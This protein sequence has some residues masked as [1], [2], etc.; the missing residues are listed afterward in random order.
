MIRL[1]SAKPLVLGRDGDNWENSVTF[2]GVRA[3]AISTHRHTSREPAFDVTTGHQP[4]R[5]QHKYEET[6]ISLTRYTL[7]VTYGFKST[8]HVCHIPTPAKFPNARPLL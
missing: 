8:P 2:L 4:N 1:A 3:S 6:M 7:V 5:E